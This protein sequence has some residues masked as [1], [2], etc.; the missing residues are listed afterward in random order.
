MAI[1]GSTPNLCPLI[2]PKLVC[3]E[4]ISMLR[5]HGLQYFGGYKFMSNIS[6]NRQ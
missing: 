1:N 5:K 4:C 2:K 6:I 3:Q